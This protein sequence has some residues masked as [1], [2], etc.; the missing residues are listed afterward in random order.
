MAAKNMTSTKF[1]NE[2]VSALISSCAAIA[3]SIT[4]IV[5]TEI[6]PV[7][8][9]LESDDVIGESETKVP[10]MDAIKSCNGSIDALTAKLGRMKGVIEQVQKDASVSINKNIRTTED[11]AAA[12]AAQK[13]KVEETTGA[14]AR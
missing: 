4:G 11:A 13:K 8:R 9:A 3:N 1:D 2:Q 5:D 10:L 6:T 7:F 12:I 14:G